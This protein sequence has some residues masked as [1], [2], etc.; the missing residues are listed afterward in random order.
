[1]KCITWY[2]RHTRSWVVQQKDENGNQV[3][4]ADYVY[5]RDEALTL[6]KEYEKTH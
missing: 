3:G 2:D 6:K 4:Q 1:M 5:T